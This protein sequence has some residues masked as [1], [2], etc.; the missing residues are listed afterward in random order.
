M[1]QIVTLFCLKID[2]LHMQTYIKTIRLSYFL[3]ILDEHKTR[4]K[5]DLNFSALLN[6]I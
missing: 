6:A 5:P 1:K 2:S 3:I 4:K